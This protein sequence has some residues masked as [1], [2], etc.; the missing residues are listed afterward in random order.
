M[1]YLIRKTIDR[2][3]KQECDQ[4]THR[5][6]FF[7]RRP[8][9]LRKQSDDD[10]LTELITRRQDNFFEVLDTCMDHQSAKDSASLTNDSSHVLPDPL[11]SFQPPHRS[12]CRR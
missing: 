7:L 1:S 2:C 11:E 12:K 6:V 5:P 4:V 10:S 3:N 8:C 9:R